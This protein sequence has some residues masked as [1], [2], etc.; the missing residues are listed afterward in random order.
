MSTATDVDPTERARDLL[1]VSR[2]TNRGPHHVAARPPRR[3]PGGLRGP[4]RRPRHPLDQDDEQGVG[5]RHGHLDD[6]PHDARGRRHP[7]QGA[8]PGAKALVPDPTDPTTPRPAAVCVYGDMVADRQ[9]RPWASAASRSRR[10]P[11]PSRAA[12]RACR[13][14]SP[15]PRMPSTAGADEIDMVIDRGAFL[16]GDYLTVFDEIAAGQGGLRRR[17]AQGDHGDRRAGHLRQRAARLVAVDARAAATSSRPP[18]ARCRPP[19]PCRSRS[20][21]LEAVRDWRETTGEMVGVKPA[22]G[23][24]DEQGRDQVP[25]QRQRGR[26]RGL[27]RQRTGSASAPRACSTTCSCSASGCAPAPT[28]APTTS[29]TT[30]PAS[31]DLRRPS[32]TDRGTREHVPLRVRPG[33]RVPGRR[34]HRDQLRP[35]H[36]R[37]VRRGHRRHAVQDRQPGDRGG[38]RRGHRGE[39][40]RRRRARS[41]AARTRIHPGLGAD[42]RRRP[43]QVPLPH[44]PDPAGAGPRVRRPRDAR[45]RQADQGGPRRRRAAGGGALLLPRGLGRQARAR[46]ARHEPATARCRRPGRAVELPA[47]H[48]GVEDRARAGLRQHGRAQARRDHAADRA[49]LRRRCASRPTCRRA[50]STSSPAPAPPA[51]PSSTTRASTSSRSPARPRS[52]R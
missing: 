23:I 33:T 10:S 5:H 50:S 24:R 3:R 44:R 48:A 25:R 51:R 46:V 35:V 12:A 40:R 26:R 31:T 49:A 45:Q 36:R 21:M 29:P 2:L 13:S 52:A 14:S 18:P 32:T 27:A 16:A 39:R 37:R 42:E 6:R 1:G 4:G 28:P 22:G 8:R 19:P 9:A 30:P 17:A 41:T 11:R 38:A 15:T 7:G 43:R 20:I 47:A 34:R